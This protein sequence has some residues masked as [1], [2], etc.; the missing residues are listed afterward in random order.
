[1]EV[2]N[3]FAEICYRAAVSGIEYSKRHGRHGVI[4]P[5]VVLYRFEELHLVHKSLWENKGGL[6]ALTAEGWL[7]AYDH[8]D[9]LD[10]KQITIDIDIPYDGYSTY[11][12]NNCRNVPLYAK[13]LKGRRQLSIYGGREGKGFFRAMTLD[14]VKALTYADHI[15]AKAN[16]MSAKKVKVNGKVRTWKRDVTRVE[17]PFKYGLY[18]YGTFDL[19]DVQA[20]NL[21]VRLS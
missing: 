9:R 12:Q 11:L 15:W 1:M 5:L 6:A 10:A 2:S 21:L 7:P 20:G 19:S 4:E 13:A 16:D 8:E 18:E 3:Q 17:V 14:E